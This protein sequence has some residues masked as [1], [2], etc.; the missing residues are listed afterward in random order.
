[1]TTQTKSNEELGVFSCSFS[2]FQISD[3]IYLWGPPACITDREIEYS[4]SQNSKAG[5]SRELPHLSP[6]F[7][8][9]SVDSVD[10]SVF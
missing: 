2:L 3:Y 6:E 9:I 4:Q 7:Q 5:Y 8:K 1:M 10:C